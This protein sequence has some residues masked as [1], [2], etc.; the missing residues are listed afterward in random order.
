MPWTKAGATPP[1]LGKGTLARKSPT[2]WRTKP[3]AEIVPT[4]AA[5]LPVSG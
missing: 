5:K 1:S 2:A 4:K 3:R